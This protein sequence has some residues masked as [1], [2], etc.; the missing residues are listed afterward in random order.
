V[1]PGHARALP[2]ADMVAPKYGGDFSPENP[3]GFFTKA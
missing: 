2:A 3:G 1:L